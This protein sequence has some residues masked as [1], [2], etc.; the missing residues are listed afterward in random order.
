MKILLLIALS[1]IPWSLIGGIWCAANNS[2]GWAFA[3]AASCLLCL[4]VAG[5]EYDAI[6]A[7]REWQDSTRHPRL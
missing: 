7:D 3:C 2:I 5:R 1:G 6:Q 4:F